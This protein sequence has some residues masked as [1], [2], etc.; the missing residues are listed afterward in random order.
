M[1]QPLSKANF[2]GSVLGVSAP[3]KPGMLHLGIGN[4]HRAHAAVYT[5][6]AM[7]AQGGDW[8]IVAVANRSRR[9]SAHWTPRTTCTRSWN[10]P[11]PVSGSM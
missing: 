6:K 9:W 2:T 7:A 11:A 4:F 3:P 8:G 5:A 1:T 10:C